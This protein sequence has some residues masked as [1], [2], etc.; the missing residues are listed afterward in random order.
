M[1]AFILGMMYSTTNYV[2]SKITE[3]EDSVL[4]SVAAGTITGVMYK[5][6]GWI[7]IS[8]HHHHHLCSLY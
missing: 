6:T 1:N 4:N 7:N 2:I 5:S 8:A 3:Q